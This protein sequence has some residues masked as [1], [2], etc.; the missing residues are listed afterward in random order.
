MSFDAAGDNTLDTID[1]RLI[2]P[3][4]RHPLI[5]GAF[6]KLGTDQAFVLVNDHDPHPLHYQ[7][8][9]LFAGTYSWDYLDQ[10]PEVWRV[11][12]G[13]VASSGCCGSCGGGGH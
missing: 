4:Q 13:K 1:I 7:F 6:E 10:G 11:R 9:A 8:E 2:P 5:F 3:R 12:I